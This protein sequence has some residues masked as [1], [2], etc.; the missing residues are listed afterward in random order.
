[1]GYYK[2]WLAYKIAYELAKEIFVITKRFP[3]EERF[4]AI[5][6][7]RD[8]SRSVCANLAEAYMRS[9]SLDFFLSKLNDSATENAETEVWLDFCKDFEYI[10]QN[11][12]EY[13]L[14]KNNQVGK[15]LWH[16]DQNPDNFRNK[17]FVT[18]SNKRS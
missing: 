6:Q 12:W 11:E 14:E 18:V 3:K 15:L 5:S 10:T 17:K 13:L 7:I 16:M 8:S 9:R 1:M 2:D 4:G